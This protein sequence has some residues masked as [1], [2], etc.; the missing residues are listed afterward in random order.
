MQNWFPLVPT[1]HSPAL[2]HICL[3]CPSQSYLVNGD[4]S[5]SLSH[6]PPPVP[7]MPLP[8]PPMLLGRCNTCIRRASVH[9][10]FSLSFLQRWSYNLLGPATVR[11][12]CSGS[13]CSFHL[14][15]LSRWL[16]WD[17]R[18]QKLISFRVTS[19]IS[20]LYKGLSRVFWSTTVQKLS[21]LSFTVSYGPVSTSIHDYWKNHSFDTTGFCSKVNF[22]FLIHHPN[23]S[24][25]FFHARS[26]CV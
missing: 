20:L 17:S 9:R 16:S 26:K 1:L 3:L 23:F 7:R 2:C 19:L 24:L 18:G 4:P 21:L 25:F 10:A 8:W 12:F 5:G 6:P 15:A 14:E 13:I 11:H 22:C